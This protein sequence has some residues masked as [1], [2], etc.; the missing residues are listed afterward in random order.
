[1]VD[2]RRSEQVESFNRCQFLHEVLIQQICRILQGQEVL[3][4]ASRCHNG[5][6]HTARLLGQLQSKPASSAGEPSPLPPRPT[7]KKPNGSRSL[8]SGSPIPILSIR[9]MGDGAPSAGLHRVPESPPSPP[10]AMLRPTTWAPPPSPC[11]VI[12]SDRS[13]TEAGIHLATVL[14]LFRQTE[15][16]LHAEGQQE[17]SYPDGAGSRSGSAAPSRDCFQHCRCVPDVEVL[18]TR[19]CCLQYGIQDD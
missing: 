11:D 17:T 19:S 16:T 2:T 10:I 15:P 13:I 8:S 3:P 7:V 12:N 14:K 5:R 1:M 18:P 4:S 6:S 9:S